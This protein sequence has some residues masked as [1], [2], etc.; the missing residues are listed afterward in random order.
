MQGRIMTYFSIGL[1]PQLLQSPVKKEQPLSDY[2]INK[3]H[4]LPGPWEYSFPSP[5]ETVSSLDFSSRHPVMLLKCLATM[6]FIS[7]PYLK[8]HPEKSLK[9]RPLDAGHRH[10]D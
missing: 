5:F 4:Y 10:D 3:F 6:T 1:I 9:S 2:W 8:R 7:F